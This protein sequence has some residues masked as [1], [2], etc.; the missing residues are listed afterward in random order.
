MKNKKYN[1][2]RRL[3]LLLLCFHNFNLILA[4]D[5]LAKANLEQTN[6]KKEIDP[7]LID[8]IKK[9]LS[10]FHKLEKRVFGPQ[11]PFTDYLQI[12]DCLD[13]VKKA[14]DEK[15]SDPFFFK[16]EHEIK[17]LLNK[18]LV[19]ID[20]FIN[21]FEAQEPKT[22][23]TALKKRNNQQVTDLLANK[24]LLEFKLKNSNK[25]ELE[26]VLTK[27]E[28]RLTIFTPLAEDYGRSFLQK[29]V[30]NIEYYDKKTNFSNKTKETI[31]S[32]YA[33]V[34]GIARVVHIYLNVYNV[35]SSKKGKKEGT[36]IGNKLEE[37]TNYLDQNDIFKNVF[38]IDFI[39]KPLYDSY[40]AL[41]SDG[42]ENELFKNFIKNR[43]ND[44]DKYVSKPIKNIYKKIGGTIIEQNYS[45]VS[46]GW[47]KPKYT[48]DDVIG[49]EEIKA[50][51]EYK[52]LSPI[53]Q[54]V[55]NDEPYIIPHG[56]LFEGISRSGKSFMAEALAGELQK[57]IPD[58]KFYLVTARDILKAGFKNI[59]QW[60][61]RHA[62]MVMIIDEIDLCDLTRDGNNKDK[63]MEA[64]VYLSSLNDIKSKKPVIVIGATNKIDKLDS[65]LRQNG[66]FS[67]EIPFT[68]PS[69][70]ERKRFLDIT[71]K[72][73]RISIDE[74]NLVDICNRLENQSFETVKSCINDAIN[75]ADN[76]PP[77]YENFIQAID[78]LVHGIKPYGKS[79]CSKN[80]LAMASCYQLGK[81]FMLCQNNFNKF[82]KSRLTILPVRTKPSS[83]CK[84]LKTIAT[85]GEIFNL[86][87]NNIESKDSLMTEV[88]FLV[89][90][91]ITQEVIFDQA[92]LNYR[93]YDQT[94][95]LEILTKIFSNGID[96][97]FLQKDKKE[98]IQL[99]AFNEY[100]KIKEEVR[101]IIEINKDKI[102]NATKFLLSDDANYTIDCQDLLKFFISSEQEL[103]DLLEKLNS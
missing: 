37:L 16:N 80:E 73:E 92:N 100:E 32:F 70:E 1:N 79:T 81:S 52:I 63:L 62:P 59:F 35:I 77:Q 13:Y 3:S 24:N 56:W 88:R 86:E 74:N 25:L 7:Q 5:S 23:I 18:S 22:L 15:L 9:T 45:E 75:R 12:R 61:K 71:L 49:L 4:T 26:E 43:R 96:D 44:L 28:E 2:F 99:K 60:S 6:P 103:K 85:L 38:L 11:S 47:T 50:E 68:Y 10:A 94:K 95:A 41:S 40:I 87:K 69:L 89:A 67:E 42:E 27:V 54:G 58:S 64:L 72:K 90:G 82:L 36:A 46:D 14:F 57:I 51:L 84:D 39:G 65:A 93:E 101:E 20:Y 91:R 21:L 78:N 19:I 48:F 17:L 102:I 53:R 98:E 31:S 8:T 55:K 83:D 97:K 30:R 33:P 76:C 66:R 34:T 29:L